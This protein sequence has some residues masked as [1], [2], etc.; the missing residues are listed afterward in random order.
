[1][2]RTI[3]AA[4]SLCMTA[5]P[6]YSQ[7]HP[8]YENPEMFQRNQVMPHATMMPYNSLEEALA[9]NRKNSSR[10]LMLNGNWQ[11][12]WAANP[13]LAPEGFYLEEKERSGWDRIRVPSN[14]QMEGFGY[15]MFRNIGL[16]HPLDPPQVPDDFNPV[17]SYFRT[18]HLPESWQGQRIHLHFEG[19][20]SAS[21]VWV[22]GSEVG[23]NQ[24][25]MEPAVYD[26]TPYLNKGK[27]SVAVRVLRYCDGSYLEDQDTWRLSGIYRD[28][29]LVARS[30][31][32]VGDF[33][34]VTDLDESCQNASLEVEARLVNSSGKSSGP[35]QW[36]LT[37]YDRIGRMVPGT[38]AQ[39]EAGPV[40]R[41]RMDTIRCSI[42]VRRPEKWSAEHPFLYTLVMEL[43]DREGRVMELLSNRVGFREVEVKDQ[44]LLVNGV[45]VKLN[46]VNSH[47]MHPETGHAMDT[48]TMREDLTLMKQFNIN[49]VRTS[50]YPPN[51]EYL[52][53]ADELGIYI[54]DE[55][56]NE[57]HG[58]TH[59]SG[60]PEWREQYLDRM[61][62]MVYRDRNHPSVI[63][64]SAGNESGPGENIC[65]LISEG[66]KIDPGRPAW[67]Y[68]GNRDE[69][70]ATNPIACED[71]VGPRY[72]QPFRLEHRFARAD[73]PRPSFMDEY[74]A[75]TGNSLGGMDEYWE[76][77]RQYPR[78]SGGAIWD[79]VSP[80][81]RWPVRLTTDRSPN[82]ITT[83]LMNRAH[84]VDGPS[85]KALHLSG[86]D[87]WVEV[88]RDPALDIVGEELTLY[89]EVKPGT[90]PGSSHFLAKGDY[91]YGILQPDSGY[92]EFYVNTGRRRAVR[93]RLPGGWEGNW[94]QVA[95][96]YD[97]AKMELYVDGKIIGT[98][99]C[100][101]RILNAPF[102][103][104]IGKSAELWDSHRGYL[105]RA[106]IDRIGIF[107]R[108]MDPDDLQNGGEGL[109]DESLLWLDF[110][111]CRENGVY[112]TTGLPGRTYGLVWPDRQVQP[113]LWQMK[114]SAQ[115]VAFKALDLETGRVEI[116][117]HYHFTAL[118]KLQVKWELSVD[119]TVIRQGLVN[120][121]LEPGGRQVVEIPFDP[122]DS[123]SILS[124]YKRDTAG[125]VPVSMYLSP[126]SQLLLLFSVRTRE[127]SSWAPAGHEVA[128]EQFI[129]DTDPF[130]Y[131]IRG[132]PPAVDS[133]GI[134]IRISG[135]DFRYEFDKTTGSLLSMEVGGKELVSS[136]PG[137]NVWRAPLANDLDAW[138]AWHTEMGCTLDWMGKHTA[139]G[140][141]SIGLDR[142]EQVMDRIGWYTDS[143]R[144]VVEV[145]TS[146]HAGNYTTGFKVW[147]RYAIDNKGVIA[148]TTRA[149]PRGNMTR[150]IPKMG[151]QMVLPPDFCHL[152]WR[153][154]GPMENYPDRKTG[155][156]VGRYRTTVEQDDQP[157]LIPQE[158]GNRSGV[159]WASL[160]DDQGTG[161]FVTSG[162]RFHVSAQKYPTG[163]LDRARYRFQLPEQESVTFNLDCQVSGVGGTANSV[164]H[165]YQVAPREREFT[166]YIQPIQ[167]L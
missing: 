93:G 154:R 89:M 78:L 132:G 151:L 135:R 127:E 133:A 129:L 86:H 64:W 22:N 79:W 91:Q 160:T 3:V 141:Y 155:A 43:M 63:F 92:L 103:V 75:A 167:S 48:A 62:K 33:Y 118:D 65:S 112:F 7:F 140:W 73:D 49:C 162:E 60:L 5:G 14:W 47:M 83:A 77:I 105:C 74:I 10:C 36:R 145:E 84:L 6:V 116:T 69:D 35:M 138:N 144:V 88:Y 42:P 159:I 41:G 106:E 99:A 122:H 136:G 153:G 30:S 94:H 125:R 147:Y 164:L 110:E 12:H 53:L 142:L 123:S 20:Q 13:D 87:D 100:R 55:T 114:K 81:I 21:Y 165:P 29:Y 97:G 4:L 109:R 104:T 37:L 163:H 120:T 90:Y 161:I 59:L 51:V 119:G 68:G 15:P 23:Y 71:I 40:R 101:G 54:V 8:E 32:H 34:L 16:P 158:Y 27:N 19:I 150:W 11:F 76:L 26:I 1:M 17:G 156:K 166:F 46:G 107:D 70:P 72:L 80:G 61:R 45:A 52:D 148:L 117:N 50:H 137:F 9:G 128:W 115:P 139:N 130:L 58:Y 66:K 56:G 131:V 111:T 95:G 134:R 57:A 143:S 102:G 157:Y 18:F 2:N 113:E 108:S 82:H 124:E 96:I 149:S 146:Q 31:V 44:A 25:G 121:A 28:V 85:G 98:R 39:I 67:M 152:E 24:G 126:E 38:R